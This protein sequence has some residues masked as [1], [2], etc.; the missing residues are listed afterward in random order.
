MVR[1]VWE[2]RT[3]KAQQKCR[4]E[5]HVPNQARHASVLVQEYNDKR[6]DAYKRDNKQS[7]DEAIAQ[8]SGVGIL[9]RAVHNI[10]RL[11]QRGRC[12]GG[13]FGRGDV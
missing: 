2:K 13:R 8:L 6:Q 12:G 11:F 5:N 10:V 9:I 3:Q 4:T 7:I 1:R